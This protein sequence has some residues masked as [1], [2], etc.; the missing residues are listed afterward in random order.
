MASRTLVVSRGMQNDATCILKAKSGKLDIET[1]KPG[2][3][4]SVYKLVHSSNDS[5]YEGFY[6]FCVNSTSFNVIVDIIRKVQ[7]LHDLIKTHG[8]R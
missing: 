6:P 4:L 2:I 3:L 1:H 7:R 5:D 8:M